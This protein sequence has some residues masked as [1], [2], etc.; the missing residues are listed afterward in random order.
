MKVFCGAAGKWL[1]LT[2]PA[3]MVL[4]SGLASA[5]DVFAGK[6]DSEISAGQANQKSE[7]SQVFIANDDY[8]APDRPVWGFIDETGK[9]VSEFLFEDEFRASRGSLYGAIYSKETTSRAKLKRNVFDFSGKLLL[10][11]HNQEV[12]VF[13]SGLLA[14]S[15]GELWGFVDTKGKLVISHRFTS[16][17]PFYHD[18]APVYRGRILQVIDRKGTV[19]WSQDRDRVY[20]SD[21]KYGIGVIKLGKQALVVQRQD[22]GFLAVQRWFD[23]GELVSSFF[24]K[25]LNFDLREGLVNRQGA[26]ILEPSYATISA[27]SSGRAVASKDDKHFII[28]SHGKVLSELVCAKRTQPIANR[29]IIV[30]ARQ[31]Q[32][33]S[34]NPALVAALPLQQQALDLDGKPLSYGDYLTISNYGDDNGLFLVSRLTSDGVKFG[35][36]NKA[37]KE[38]I[39]CRFGT[40]RD[41]HDGYAPVALASPSYQPTYLKVQEALDIERFCRESIKRAVN[42]LTF[43]K[44]LRF[45]V[46]FPVDGVATLSLVSGSGDSKTDALIAVALA[47]VEMKRRPPVWKDVGISL[48]YVISPQGEVVGA[49]DQT[50]P[51][52]AALKE[53]EE[54]NKDSNYAYRL[55]NLEQLEF[56]LKH[57][58]ELQLAVSSKALNYDFA[59]RQLL[60]LYVL[61]GR[62]ADA[63]ALLEELRL[64][65]SPTLKEFEADYLEAIGS[66][67][68]LID[69]LSQLS[70][71]GYIKN[72]R[73]GFAYYAKGKFDRAAEYFKR[74]VRFVDNL[75]S[76]NNDAFGPKCA[77]NIPKD[78]LIC[79][80]CSLAEQG[81]L[82]GASAAIDDLHRRL[83]VGDGVGMNIY[84]DRSE[85][86]VLNLIRT[87]DIDL[88]KLL[89]EKWSKLSS[90]D[91]NFDCLEFGLVTKSGQEMVAQGFNEIRNAD[92]CFSDGLL[93]AQDKYSG[94]FGY[95]DK[96]GEW[97][98]KPQFRFAAPFKNG[99]AFAVSCPKPGAFCCPPDFPSSPK[100][101]EEGNVVIINK[102][103][104]VLKTTRFK[105]VLALSDCVAVANDDNLLAQNAL[106]NLEGE[107]LL[108]LRF[109]AWEPGEEAS[110]DHL[111]VRICEGYEHGG[112]T[113]QSITHVSTIAL[114]K[115]AS[116]KV[117]EAKLVGLQPYRDSRHGVQFIGYKDQAGKIRIPAKFNIAGAFDGCAPVKEEEFGKA[118]YINEDGSRAFDGCFDEAGDFNGKTAVVRL[119]DKYFLIDRSGKS[120]SDS[121]TSLSY[122]KK[123]YYAGVKADGTSVI[124]NNDGAVVFGPLAAEIRVPSEDLCVIGREGKW[125]A[126]DLKG[127][128]VVAPKYDSLGDFREGLAVFSR[129]KTV[130][131]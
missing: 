96:S 31:A 79:L 127:R 84:G 25:T 91:A 115:D 83:K 58:M 65:N 100:S 105:S 130:S 9:L 55:E 57:K 33:G 85:L 99:K 88:F 61:T 44:P 76:A 120:I 119:S 28:D 19:L 26:I 10:D 34:L 107:E 14:V 36:I 109:F 46:S 56:Y 39:P 128:S 112:C 116:G 93:A 49:Q 42:G 29:G 50:S 114:Q 72:M 63:E 13:E 38:V 104:T 23:S 108:R 67:D 7:D 5:Q 11:T 51:L 32:L 1:F 21:S 81:S 77:V 106:I 113:S 111:K 47:K 125:G 131:P 95:L 124:L 6:T 62:Y 87:K 35:F 126:V 24:R 3:F 59:G 121:Y 53:L 18:Y 40:A 97:R 78:A 129:S 48:D 66:L 86:C 70:I 75:P 122:L 94:L 30:V 73:L 52:N 37:G 69:L 117:I 64:Y 103:G 98:I 15:N 90:P 54:L 45:S 74:A 8:L 101:L 17:Q 68:R 22:D 43:N 71:D 110:G 20:S 118:Y 60:K 123:G 102:E 2:L 92:V 4:D 12:D 41:F 80:A 82:K 16:I 89:K 27:F